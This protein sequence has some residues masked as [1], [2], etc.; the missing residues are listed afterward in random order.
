M[1]KFT[2]RD[3]AIVAGLAGAADFLAE[4]KF[5]AP[6]ARALKRAF[7][8]AAPVAARGV[9]AFV[10]RAL[11][12]AR[13]VAMRHP[14]IFG[15]VVTYE[16]IKHRKEIAEL[17]R[18]GWEIIEPV[19]APVGEFLMEG[20]AIGVQ[21]GLGGGGIQ[22]PRSPFTGLLEKQRKK[23]PSKFNSA[24]KA[25]MAAI[26][27]STSYGGKGKIK[28]ATKAFSIVTK[29]ASAKKK[30]KKAPKGGIR[31]KIWNAMKGLR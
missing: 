2:E 31:R 14:V 10:P 15:A 16:V 3:V 30:K 9:A 28:P 23:R 25:G 29:L 5:T 17:A 1:V 13:F 7:F 24:I 8:K 21:A 12:T 20:G 18:E 19:A 27:K 11:G 26:K 22:A 6:V 4:G